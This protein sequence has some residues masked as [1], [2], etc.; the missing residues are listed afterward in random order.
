M[1]AQPLWC[2]LP[3]NLDHVDCQNPVPA[4]E[5]CDERCPDLKCCKGFYCIPVLLDTRISVFSD[6]FE[7]SGCLT[8]FWDT[9]VT[10]K[11]PH[12]RMFWNW[13]AKYGDTPYGPRWIL[14]D[15]QNAAG[16]TLH[17]INKRMNE[18]KQ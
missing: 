1:A 9:L 5:R 14:N 16:P 13:R 17:E 8:T 10:A 4:D 7:H 6:R 2:W 18:L 12:Y 11:R 15:E 3:W